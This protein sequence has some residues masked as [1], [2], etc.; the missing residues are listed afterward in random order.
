LLHGAQQRGVRLANAGSGTLSA[1]DFLGDVK[2]SME[3][4]QQQPQEII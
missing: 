4:K 3:E 1:T 2:Y